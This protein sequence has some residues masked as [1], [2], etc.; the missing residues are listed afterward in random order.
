MTYCNFDAKQEITYITDWIKKYFIENGPNSKAI[1][2]ISGGK[3]ST[4]AAALLVQALGAE[5]VIAAG[6]TTS[7]GADNNYTGRYCLDRSSL[8]RFAMV[9]IDYSK[10]IEESM[11]HGKDDLV[12]FAHAFRNA[13]DKAGVE[14]LFSYRTIER[15]ALLEDVIP[16][17]YENMSISLLKGLNSEDV[18]TLRH[19]IKENSNMSNNKYAK[20]FIN[21]FDF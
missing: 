14:C 20:T 6:N 18:D 1:I 9:E 5:R 13:T 11:S 7:L 21:G 3:D 4:I 19:E 8:D 15:I 12:A 2:G 17:L 10:A 16:N